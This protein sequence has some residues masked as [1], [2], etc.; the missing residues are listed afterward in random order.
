MSFIVLIYCFK[1]FIFA[2]LLLLLLLRFQLDYLFPPCLCV[3]VC[4]ESY[5]NRLIDIVLHLHLPL[6]SLYLSS[7]LPSPPPY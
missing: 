1:L 2:L 4:W 7:P 5:W 6:F 3:C